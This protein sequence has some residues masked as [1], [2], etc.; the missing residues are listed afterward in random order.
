MCIALTGP[1]NISAQIESVRNS[2]DVIRKNAEATCF[3]VSLPELVLLAE[4]F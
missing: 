4:Q 1:W 3:V 2:F